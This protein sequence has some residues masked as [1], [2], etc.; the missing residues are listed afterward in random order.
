[1]YKIENNVQ[2]GILFVVSYSNTY[3]YFDFMKIDFYFN[4]K[5]IWKKLDVHLYYF[6]F[7]LSWS[8][9]ILYQI[10]FEGSWPTFIPHILIGVSLI[11]FGVQ[12]ISRRTNRVKTYPYEKLPLA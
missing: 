6:Y 4:E 2:P 12:L 1:K 9:V 7:F 8:E 11:L 10:F 5:D 3:C